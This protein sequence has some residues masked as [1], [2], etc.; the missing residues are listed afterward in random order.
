MGSRLTQVLAVA[1]F[2]A[3]FAVRA[4]A[5]T[6]FTTGGDAVFDGGPPILTPEPGTLALF[7][8]GLV[9]VG[10]WWRARRR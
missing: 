10:M 2:V 8:S 6:A 3:L 1:G 5:G 9:G 4:Y 7:G